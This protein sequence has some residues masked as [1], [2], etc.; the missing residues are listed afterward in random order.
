MLSKKKSP[1]FRLFYQYS[2]KPYIFQFFSKKKSIEGK[3]RLMYAPF[4]ASD[5]FAASG[6][7]DVLRQDRRVKL[8][9]PHIVPKALFTRVSALHKA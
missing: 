1:A 8:S 5:V 6:K 3:N 4:G 9:V 7:S 2:I